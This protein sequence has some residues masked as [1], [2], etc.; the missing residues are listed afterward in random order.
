VSVR[1]AFLDLDY[2]YDGKINVGDIIRFFG[3]ES[4]EFNI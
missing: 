4:K 3:S 2:D 1:K